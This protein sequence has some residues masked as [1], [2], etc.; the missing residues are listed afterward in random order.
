MSYVVC[1]SYLIT[2]CLFWPIRSTFIVSIYIMF[3]LKGTINRAFCGIANI[4]RINWNKENFSVPKTV[5]VKK[6]R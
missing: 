1:R 4:L 2:R 5:I 3:V 6:N